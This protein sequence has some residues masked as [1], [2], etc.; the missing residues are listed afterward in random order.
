[1]HS[2]HLQLPPRAFRV[3][4]AAVLA[5]Y[6]EGDGTDEFVSLCDG[7]DQEVLMR[8]LN[9]GLLPG[10]LKAMNA[11]AKCAAIQ[12]SGISI[13]SAICGLNPPEGV[14]NILILAGVMP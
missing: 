4:R 10:V 8:V 5:S 14:A 13:V 6:I 3:P 1:M 2:H 11:H 9:A 12:S 7:A